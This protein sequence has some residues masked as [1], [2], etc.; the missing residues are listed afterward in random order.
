MFRELTAASIR[1][2]LGA[3]DA[4]ISGRSPART[5]PGTMMSCGTWQNGA[6]FVA[7]KTASERRDLVEHFL[8]A[9]RKGTRD[10]HDAF[11]GADDK[12]IGNGPGLA[13]VAASIAKYTGEPVETAMKGDAYVDRDARL[14][15]KDV[16]H[17]IEWYKAQGMVKGEFD[18][19]TLIDKSYVKPLS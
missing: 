7:S 3:N 1:S 12:P 16:L 5:A 17:Q 18:G 15:V 8:T 13:A 11:T 10:Y 14:D 2:G 9:F 4:A 6:V 19:A